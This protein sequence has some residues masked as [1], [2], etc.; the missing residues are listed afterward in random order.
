[1]A[2][3]TKAFATA[4]S[5][6]YVTS[7]TTAPAT[8]DKTGFT[9]LTFT[10]LGNLLDLGDG[11]GKNTNT[12]DFAGINRKEIESIPT[13]FT[14]GSPTVIYAAD[15]LGTDSG[16]T[17]MIEAAEDEEY[18]FFKIVLSNGETIYFQARVNGSPLTL[19]TV[20]QLVQYSAV[21]SIYND[22]NGF[23]RVPAP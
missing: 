18:R 1:M 6:L 15:K 17:I 8:W 22:G 14:S 4:G 13:N 12:T 3:A 11:Y 23:V 16:Q 19:G 21:L 7:A 5:K 2:L 20:D 9:A 10:E